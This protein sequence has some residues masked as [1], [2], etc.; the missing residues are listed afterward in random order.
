MIDKA[1]IAFQIKD[2]VISLESSEYADARG[3]FGEDIHEGKRSLVVI[4]SYN[5]LT[6]KSKDRLLEILSM[7][8]KDSK[9]IKEAIELLNSTKSIEYAKKAEKRLIKSAMDDAKL[10]LQKQETKTNFKKFMKLIC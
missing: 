8:T 6:G 4:H 10:Y 2:D 3:I 1:S 7:K 9:I 5:N